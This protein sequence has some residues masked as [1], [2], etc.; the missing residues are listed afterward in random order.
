MHLLGLPRVCEK[1]LTHKGKKRLVRNRIE[2]IK[3]KT[4]KEIMQ[5]LR[6]HVPNFIYDPKNKNYKIYI[7]HY[8]PSVISQEIKRGSNV[9]LVGDASTINLS[10][11]WQENENNSHLIIT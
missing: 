7:D 3:Q 5:K 9:L 6:N 11:K 1:F 10:P 4:L 2:S 8:H